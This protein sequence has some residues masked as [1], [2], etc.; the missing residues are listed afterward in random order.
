M[1]L[2][3]AERMAKQLIAQ[4][5]PPGWHFGW[6]PRA[7][8]HFGLC[9]EHEG[10]PTY[11]ARTIYL[12]RPLT[13]INDAATVEWVLRHEIAHARAGVKA[14]HGPAWR[15]EAR[16]LGIKPSRCWSAT[17]GQGLTPV[18]HPTTYTMTCPDCG[19][20]AGVH[21]L[22]WALFHTQICARCNRRGKQVH[23]VVTRADGGP[24]TCPPKPKPRA[25][26]RRRYARR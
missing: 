19:A 23:F 17:M 11:Y 2:T 26:R 21:R 8:S 16:A 20:S 24:V 10:H 12:S 22:S 9:C 14:N 15:V 5:A 25:R 6:M 3:T 18:E 13:L 1:N 7:R 4:H